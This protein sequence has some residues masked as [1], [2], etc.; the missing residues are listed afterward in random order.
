M[1]IN[2]EDKYQTEI[3]NGRKLSVF[4]FEYPQV[5]ISF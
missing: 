3:R 2:M 1:K 4:V 5:V